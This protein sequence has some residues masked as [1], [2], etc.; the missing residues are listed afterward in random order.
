MMNNINISLPLGIINVLWDY[1]DYN[2]LYKCFYEFYITKNNNKFEFINKF[3]FL[4]N[5]VCTRKEEIFSDKLSIIL[6]EYSDNIKINCCGDTLIINKKQYQLLNDFILKNK[7]KYN[8]QVKYINK[9]N[10]N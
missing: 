5:N 10:L 8:F 7:D 3:Y 2:T 9:T 6:L 1:D 4:D